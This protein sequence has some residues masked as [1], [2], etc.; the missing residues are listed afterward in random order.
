MIFHKG[1]Q[2]M[3]KYNLWAVARYFYRNTRVEIEKLK[4]FNVLLTVHRDI[5]VKKKQQNILFT[6]NLFQ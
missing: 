5:S 4:E 6:F 1:I 2:N 3:K